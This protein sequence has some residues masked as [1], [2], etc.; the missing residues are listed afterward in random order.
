[1]NQTIVAGE[2]VQLPRVKTNWRRFGLLAL[3]LVCAGVVWFFMP[4]SA[5]PPEATILPPDHSIRSQ[6]LPL[7]D[8]W[9]PPTWGGLWRLR[10]ALL[11]KPAVI[12]IKSEF[13]RLLPASDARLV[14][15]LSGHEPLAATNGVCVWILL[16][17]ELR[18]FRRRLEELEGYEVIASPRITSGHG[19]QANLAQTTTATIGGAQ[20]PVGVFFNCLTCARD[21]T[22][23][24]TAAMTHSEA[25]TDLTNTVAAAV[26]G[27]STRIHTNV[28]LAAKLQIPP[29][30][31]VFLL[32]TSRADLRGRYVGIFISSKVE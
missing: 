23:V 18:A 30:N 13:V 9:I 15:A 11:G 4:N 19:V 24:L 1:M 31:G 32:D 28:T 2:S 5:L 16:D 10:Y 14:D 21:K 29:G 26:L 20:V 17:G 3:A 6:E 27:N 8:R 25:V 12:Q 7:P 22:T